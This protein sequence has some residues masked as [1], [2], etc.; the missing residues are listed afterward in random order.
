MAVT[1]AELIER[2]RDRLTDNETDKI[3][4][5]T[6]LKRYIA[7]AVQEYSRY[8]TT[9]LQ[10]TITVLANT[11]H[12]ELPE[13]CVFVSE[14]RNP[15]GDVFTAWL[16][17]GRYL[18]VGEDLI[19]ELATLTV[20]FDGFHTISADTYTTIPNTERETLLDLV[21][22]RC[23]STMAIDM[24]KRP[25]FNET[26]VRVDHQDATSKWERKARSLRAGVENRLSTT[27][28]AIG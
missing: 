2:L 4:A 17:D 20:K 7:D 19:D 22:A 26:Q 10:T 1:E 15:D 24:A 21:E 11:T 27:R 18:V 12:Y 8:R 28:G 25:M 23:L 5:D 14:V 3:F 9:R 16:Q 13:T 6:E